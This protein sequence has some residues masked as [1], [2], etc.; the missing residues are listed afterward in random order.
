MSYRA[1]ENWRD[2]CSRLCLPAVLAILLFTVAS[3]A[4]AD[5]KF[6]RPVE[7]IDDR[8]DILFQRALL[9][10]RDGTETLVI[11]SAVDSQ[12]TKLAWVMPLPGVPEAI[13]KVSV[14]LFPTLEN[15]TALRPKDADLSDDVPF[16]LFAWAV[17]AAAS[18]VFWFPRP[19][20]GRFLASLLIVFGVGLFLPAL[21]QLPQLST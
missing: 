17:I 18:L 14:G 7:A 16:Y 9:V 8:P 12:S 4:Y 21:A 5:G 20:F 10:W 15:A 2:A 19:T 13:E 6:F 3:V 11:E 1:P